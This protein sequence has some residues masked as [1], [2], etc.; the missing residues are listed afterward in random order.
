MEA[1]FGVHVHAEIA[2]LFREIVCKEASSLAVVFAQ[3]GKI[4]LKKI[5]KEN[6]ISFKKQVNLPDLVAE[7]GGY[8]TYDFAILDEQ[9]EIIRL[10]EFDGNQHVRPYD[11]FGG[12]EKFEKVKKNDSL[13]NEYAISHNIPLV[14]IPYSKRDS[15]TLDDLLGDRYTITKQ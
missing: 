15:M 9:E 10:I 11:Y 1:H 7:F 8:P 3:Q 5:L 6:N 4:I 13:K 14:R 12:E 2:L